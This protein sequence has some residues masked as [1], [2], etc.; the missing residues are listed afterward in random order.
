MEHVKLGLEAL[1]I[2]EGAYGVVQANNVNVYKA[3]N[4]KFI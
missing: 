2:V 3:N 1:M 4:P